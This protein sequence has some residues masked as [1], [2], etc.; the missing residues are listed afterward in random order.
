MKNSI[1]KKWSGSIEEA[2]VKNEFDRGSRVATDVRLVHLKHCTHQRTHVFPSAVED[3][4]NELLRT[5][6]MGH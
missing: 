1:A 4:A 3:T 2:H 6:A 5:S